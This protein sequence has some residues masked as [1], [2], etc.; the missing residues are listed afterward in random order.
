VSALDVLCGNAETGSSIV[1]VGG[2]A[3]GCEIAAE[4]SD[5]TSHVAICEQLSELAPDLFHANRDMLLEML[6]QRGVSI[7]TDT[8]FEK[9]I[10]GGVALKR[11]DGS[12]FTLQADTVIVSIGMIP[13]DALLAELNEIVEEVY[14][15]GDC[16]SPRRVKDAVWEAFKKAIRI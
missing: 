16:V 13:V 6:E 3:T 2:G 9:I 15:I 7:F 14:S 11:K 10:S 1:I 12:E 4:L 8:R 5:G